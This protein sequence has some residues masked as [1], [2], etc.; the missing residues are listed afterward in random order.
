MLYI[1]WTWERYH[2]GDSEAYSVGF[3]DVSY[4]ETA[5]ASVLDV[6]DSLLWAKHIGKHVELILLRSSL[7]E[8]DFQ[9][10]EIRSAGN[11]TYV[12]SFGLDC[13][14]LS[15]TAPLLQS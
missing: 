12:S 5:P 9:V 15:A 11:S 4:F 14:T 13:V 6:S 2:G 7:P 10:L 8:R 3:A 1:S